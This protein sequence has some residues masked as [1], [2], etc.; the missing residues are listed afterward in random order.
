MMLPENNLKSG[1]DSYTKEKLDD[2]LKELGKT[3]R[4][5][6]GTKTPAE[7]ILVGGAAIVAGYGFRE[8]TSDIDALI[9]ASSAMT[10]AI[11]QIADQ[12]GLSRDWLNQD[13]RK[14]A[15]YSDRIVQYS[16]PYRTFS[17]ILHVRTLPAEYVAAMKLASLREYKYDFSDVVGIVK[18]S[19]ITKEQIIE[20]IDKLYGSIDRL[21]RS[22]EAKNLLEDIYSSKELKALY[23]SYRLK[24]Q[25]GFAILKSLDEDPEVSLSRDNVNEVIAAARKRK[26]HS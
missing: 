7:V 26:N 21:D 25:E 24:E 16:V 19:G 22:E 6:N 12:Y 3:F 5:M 13:F 14:T 17:N 18:E 8:S 2:V 4:K 15:S 11:H 20:A 1:K 9:Q 10:D 23:D